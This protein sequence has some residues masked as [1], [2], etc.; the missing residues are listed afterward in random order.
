MT[1]IEVQDLASRVR[2][3]VPVSEAL[4]QRELEV[5]GLVARGGNDRAV[6]VAAAYDRGLL[7]P[8][9]EPR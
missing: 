5:P 4:S 8:G 7:T 6:A 9:G 2:A 1:V 3:P